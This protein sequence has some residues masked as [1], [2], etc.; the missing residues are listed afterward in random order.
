MR[1]DLAIFHPGIFESIFIEVQLNNFNAIIGEIYTKYVW[2]NP[3]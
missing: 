2:I 3:Y 1:D